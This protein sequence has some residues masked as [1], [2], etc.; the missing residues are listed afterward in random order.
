MLRMC[1]W[2]I[3]SIHPALRYAQLYTQRIVLSTTVGKKPEAIHNYPPCCVDT[4]LGVYPCRAQRS[5]PHVEGRE[6][7]DLGEGRADSRRG[8]RVEPVAAAGSNW[9][10]GW[11]VEL[12][13]NL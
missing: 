13:K 1:G 5:R 6:R 4:V 11:S 9:S 10:I 2:I 12:Q 8:C 3:A 7:R